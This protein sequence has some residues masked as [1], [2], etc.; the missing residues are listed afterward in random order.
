MGATF[1]SIFQNDRD[2][3]VF[4]AK[5]RYVSMFKFEYAPALKNKWNDYILS[6]PKNDHDV[7]ETQ[8]ASLSINFGILF[9]T[10]EQKNMLRA[11]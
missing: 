3:N 8:D 6:H 9:W 2:V 11:R 4:Y 1:C 7:T 5:P 10:R